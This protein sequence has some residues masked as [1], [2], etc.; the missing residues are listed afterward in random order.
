MTLNS[1]TMYDTLI[2]FI[3]TLNSNT[4]GDH[5]YPGRRT[6]TCVPEHNYET[7]TGEV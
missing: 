3:I 7:T 2:V 1:N 4:D 5:P 6:H